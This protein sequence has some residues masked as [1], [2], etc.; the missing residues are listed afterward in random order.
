MTWLPLGEAVKHVDGQTDE[1]RQRLLVLE[2]VA[3]RKIRYQR[4]IGDS[5]K[6]EPPRV[7]PL[8]LHVWSLGHI[9]WAWN[10]VIFVDEVYRVEVWFPDVKY[11]DRRL[12]LPGKHGFER[13]LI[14]KEFKRRVAAGESTDAKRMAKYLK[15]FPGDMTG[16][17]LVPDG[18][19]RNWLTQL[20][21][22]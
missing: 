9:H 3:G 5:E 4:R 15:E 22:S 11:D 12:S 17:A 21:N 18:T 6:L 10:V 8:P 1:G 13:L 7:G 16:R 14:E 2:I 20:K 19:L